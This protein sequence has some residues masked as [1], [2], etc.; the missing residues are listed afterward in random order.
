M[1]AEVI[2]TDIS[3]ENLVDLLS[4]SMYGSDRFFARV[5]KKE[6][7]K[8]RTDGDCH[9]DKLA[10]VLLNGGK[11]SIYDCYAEDETD[12]YGDP[13]LPHEYSED[14]E[15]MRYDVTLHDV[16]DGL[17]RAFESEEC[18]DF[19]KHLMYDPCQMDLIEADALL[20]FILFGDLIYG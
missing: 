9:E 10:R 15:A 16:E 11:I 5:K 7:D 4:V 8:V 20:Q 12:F 13:A 17:A 18:C 1:K 6:Y 2:I 3:H 14:D 19:V